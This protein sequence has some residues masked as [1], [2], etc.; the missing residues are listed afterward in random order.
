MV[1]IV[2]TKFKKAISD[3]NSNLENRAYRVATTVGIIVFA[4]GVFSS[5]IY[6]GSLSSERVQ[7]TEAFQ[8]EQADY[9]EGHIVSRLSTYEELLIA[10]AALRKMNTS[11]TKSDWR[12][13]YFN[14]RI[15]ERAPELLGYGYIEYVPVNTLQDYVRRAKLAVSSDYTVTPEGDREEYAPIKYIEPWNDVNS[16]ALGYDMYSEADRYNAMI[17]AKNSGEPTLSAPVVTIQDQRN[18]GASQVQGLLMFYPIYKEDRADLGDVRTLVGYSYIVFRVDDIMKKVNLGESEAIS[19]LYLYDNGAQEGSNLLYSM[20]SGSNNEGSEESKVY[21]R[22]LDILSRKWTMQIKVKQKEVSS[23]LNP[24]RVFARGVFISLLLGSVLFLLLLKRA[25]DINKSHSIDLQRTKDELLALASHQLRTPAT[26]VRQYVGMLVQGYFG[27]L[28]TEQ[29]S[30]AKKAYDTNERQL[31][32][33]D[34]LLYVAK[35]DAGQL[36]VAFDTLDIAKITKD[37]IASY[38]NVARQKDIQ[39][40]YRGNKK[41]LCSGDRRYIIM[42]IENLVS[43][44][45]KYSYPDSKVLLEL[46]IVDSNVV[47]KVK[48][49]GIGISD[50]DKDKLFQ[51]FSRIDS[52]LS[53]SEGGSGLGLFLAQK[54]AEAHGGEIVV[55]PRRERGS[56]F[57]LT[58][59]IKSNSEKNVIQLTV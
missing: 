5:Y 15:P 11:V 41:L 54:L 21:E 16:L 46:T 38:E 6:A 51:K 2:I 28:N 49:Q 44:A 33:I 1:M 8:E 13:I 59:P 35:A 19:S 34:Q 58:I 3:I 26:G 43:N 53:R 27:P 32:I 48:D 30:I 12:N 31:E 22:N 47:L 37:V 23:L 25:S 10:G 17:T 24:T 56:N 14:L 50:E 39:I 7:E 29:L 45:V 52:S 18:P 57:I 42:I 36:V 40:Y 9:V 4:L 55:K 20:D